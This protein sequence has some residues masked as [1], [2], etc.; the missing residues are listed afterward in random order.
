MG[1]EHHQH[2]ANQS[3]TY[4]P[5]EGSFVK[6]DHSADNDGMHGS[7][8]SL[9]FHFGNSETILFNFWKPTNTGGIA[10]SCVV[11]VIMCFIMEFLRFLR[12]YRS[13]KKRPVIQE[14]I[15]LEVSVSSFALF[16]AG[17]HFA[18]LTISYL[19]MLIFMTFNVW[20]CGSVLI[21]EVGSRLLFTIL[22]PYLAFGSS[23][24]GC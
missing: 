8:H 10:L 6:M 22:F 23:S 2:H 1:H 17:L 21:G 14:R 7:A 15:G 18:Q 20:L 24:N 9:A 19:L 3:S 11:V 12:A 16:D 4:I 13:A 5:L